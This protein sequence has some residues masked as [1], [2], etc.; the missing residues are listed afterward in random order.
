MR[1]SRGGRPAPAGALAGPGGARGSGPGAEAGLGRGLGSRR[2][3]GWVC[4]KAPGKERKKVRDCLRATAHLAKYGPGAATVELDGADAFVI[5]EVDCGTGPEVWDDP[6]QRLGTRSRSPVGGS[7]DPAEFRGSPVPRGQRGRGAQRASVS[8]SASGGP[9][10]RRA[11]GF[12]T[13]QSGTRAP[14]ARSRAGAGG[15]PGDARPAILPPCGCCRA[16][17]GHSVRQSWALRLSLPRAA[18]IVDPSSACDAAP[19]RAPGS[20]GKNDA[21][22]GGGRE[23]AAGPVCA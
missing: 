3:A 18:R 13:S 4:K 12:P 5:M 17:V 23:E 1:E 21:N 2:G 20:S 22:G 9:L 14:A 19:R 7:G 8:T 16:E 11:Q 10:A 6:I 15:R